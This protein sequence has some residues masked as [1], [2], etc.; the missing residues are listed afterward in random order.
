MS[1]KH[2]IVTPINM[3]LI[4]MGVFIGILSLLLLMGLTHTINSIFFSIQLL[5]YFNIKNV[6][7]MLV[8]RVIFNRST[9]NFQQFFFKITNNF[10]IWMERKKQNN[11]TMIGFKQNNK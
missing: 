4:K 9:L 8:A 2:L 6:N 3:V 7:Y 11:H 1:N 10:P 5:Y